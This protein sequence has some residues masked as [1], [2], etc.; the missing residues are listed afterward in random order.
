VIEIEKEQLDELLNRNE[1]L[2][3]RCRELLQAE[4]YLKARIALLEE[5][6]SNRRIDGDQ[7]MNHTFP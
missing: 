5:R 2:I 1:I 3:N 7:A 4:R 6:L